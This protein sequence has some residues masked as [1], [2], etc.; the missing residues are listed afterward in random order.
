MRKN[1]L[2]LLP[3]A[4]LLALAISG[5]AQ[6]EVATRAAQLVVAQPAYPEEAR[7]AQQ[8]GDIRLRMTITPQG[9]PESISFYQSSGYAELDN[10]AMAAAQQWR[11]TPARNEN[12][13]PVASEVIAPVLFQLRGKRIAASAR[14]CQEVLERVD[15]AQQVAP[16]SWMGAFDVFRMTEWIA[17]SLHGAGPE[18]SRRF[19]LHNSA[20]LPDFYEGVLA[21]CR[22][23]P[24]MLYHDVMLQ[25]LRDDTTSNSPQQEASE[26][27]K[28]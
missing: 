24:Q 11:F 1:T 10:A 27:N 13:R 19:S 2:P 15:W 14:S 9:R 7:Q 26:R 23:M 25:A 28:P 4:L 12:G 21:R 5:R 3:T 18:T 6:A 20:Q 17:T 8:E 22:A 16:G